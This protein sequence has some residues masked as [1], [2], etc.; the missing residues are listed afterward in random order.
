MTPLTDSPDVENRIRGTLLLAEERGYN[1]SI[2]QLSKNLLGGQVPVSELSLFLKTHTEFDSDGVFVA[3]K[4]N[5]DAE[6]CR[7][8]QKSH[9]ELYPL[10]SHVATQYISHYVRLC[11]WVNCIAVSGSMT[12]DGLGPGDDIDLDV[13]VPDGLKYTSYLLGVLLS[14]L[15]TLRYAR[16]FK[17]FY[18]ICVS[19]VW[20]IPQTL[21]FQR[22]DGQ[23]AFELLNTNPWYNADF[24][25]YVISQNPWLKNYFPQLYETHG[26]KNHLRTMD[27]KHKKG[28]LTCLV[29][30]ASKHLLFLTVKL[31]MNTVFRHHPIRHHMNVKYPYA[32]FDDPRKKLTYPDNS[33]F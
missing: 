16:A 28:M 9:V 27:A 25:S 31:T 32:L 4:G 20:E 6:K 3:T 19:V 17:R 33:D 24:F 23:L 5:L 8:R 2:E 22:N 11:P 13:I 14:M 21:P 26:A 18:V 1:L 12:S 7:T 15:Y 30:S 10:Y 29:E